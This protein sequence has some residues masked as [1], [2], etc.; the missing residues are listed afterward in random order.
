MIDN[1]DDADRRVTDL[2]VLHRCC[3]ERCGRIARPGESYCARCGEEIEAL[4]KL[5]DLEAARVRP[6]AE[7]PTYLATAAPASSRLAMFAVASAIGLVIAAI[8][9]L[10]I[11][12]ARW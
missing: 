5:W 2:K 9:A 10:G 3:D 7:A 1:L 6:R 12:L 8:V 11:A 4:R